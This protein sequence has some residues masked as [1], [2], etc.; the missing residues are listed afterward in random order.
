MSA[1]GRAM[2]AAAFWLAADAQ[3]VDI[4]G[5]GAT[6]PAPLYYTWIQDYTAANPDVSITYDAVGSG[7]GVKRFI[8]GAVDFGASDNAMTDEEIA[9]VDGGVVLI[10]ATAGAVALAYNIPGFEGELRLSRETLLSI[11]SGEITEWDDPRIAEDNPQADFPHRTIAIVVR[12]DS[13]GTTFAFTNH[14]SALSEDW[15]DNGPGTGR[16]V[17]WPRSMTAYGNDGVAGRIRVSDYS[18]GYVELG[19][20]ERLGLPVA[21]LQNREGQFV[22]PTA[23]SSAAALDAALGEMPD[24]ARQFLPDPTG[25]ASYPIV[26]Y[27]WL[28]LRKTYG[29]QAVRDALHDFVAW[30]LTDGQSQSAEIG[31]VPLPERVAVRAQEILKLARVAE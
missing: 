23:A 29:D 9:E 16:L 15:R 3:A 12:R 6:F 21:A 26:T 5:A 25:P 20:A 1:T 2:A 10:P 27:S 31:Y 22:R 17:D 30:G 8:A 13:S 24:D 7:E 18:I 19:F 14:L 11:F 4:H 28:M